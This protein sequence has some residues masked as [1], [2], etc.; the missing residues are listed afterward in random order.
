MFGSYLHL[1]SHKYFIKQTQLG[2]WYQFEMER[3]L[4]RGVNQNLYQETRGKLIPRESGKPFK[5]PVYFGEP[6][7]FGGGNTWG[8]SEA[9]AVIMHQ[10]DSSKYPSSGISTTPIFENAKHYATHNGKHASG[11]VYKIDTSLLK[12]ANVKAYP[13]DDHAV[14][15]AVPDDNEVILVA[16]GFRDLPDEVIVEIIEV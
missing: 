16:E 11:Y 13:V 6:I 4:Y 2:C 14:K 15:P 3:Y 8:E 9:N 7:Y 5:R 10:I 12:A 1:E